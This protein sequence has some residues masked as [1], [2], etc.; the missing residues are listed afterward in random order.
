MHACAPSPSPARARPGSSPTPPRS[1]SPRPTGRPGV[2]EALAGAD[3]AAAQ[4]VAT[5]REHTTPERIGTTGVQI[6]PVHDQEGRP[7]R[8]RGPPLPRPSGCPD[9][10]TAGALL[11][12]LAEARRRPAPGRGRLA[13]AGRPDGAPRPEPARRRTPTRSTART[14]LA[15]LA[16]A[17]LGDPQAGAGGWPRGAPV[18]RAVKASL[19]AD[20]AR[21][22]RD[23][24]VV[25]GDGDLPAAL[26]SSPVPARRPLPHS[27][28]AVAPPALL[29]VATADKC[30]SRRSTG[31]PTETLTPHARPSSHA[32][33]EPPAVA[34]PALRRGCNGRQVR[35]SPVD[36]RSRPRPT[37]HAGPTTWA[38]SDADRPTKGRPAPGVAWA[39]RGEH[40]RAP[41]SAARAGAGRCPPRHATPPGDPPHRSTWS[42]GERSTRATTCSRTSRP[43]G[44]A[45]RAGPRRPGPGRHG[46]GVVAVGRAAEGADDE[47]RV[48]VHDQLVGQVGH[49]AGQPDVAGDRR[50]RPASSG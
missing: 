38:T 28:P 3:S 35:E 50:E 41:A 43:R 22:R 13:G 29:G 14:Q 46:P 12:A 32:S 34:L 42:R 44:P 21:A 15:T 1:G 31:D 37:P 39:P 7:D 23:G 47:R 9:V 4:I 40:A 49:R 5:A 19:S 33:L 45:S 18:G 25:V 11:T 48:A 26:T 24:R 2:A 8:V 20:L 6:W 17:A 27:T 30:R 10:A 36:R 16:G